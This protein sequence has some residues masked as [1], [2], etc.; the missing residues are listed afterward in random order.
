MI[1]KVEFEMAKGNC[2]KNLGL[3][4]K[5]IAGKWKAILDG[6]PKNLRIGDKADETLAVFE[7]S[8]RPLHDLSPVMLQHEHAKILFEKATKV[9]FDESETPKD[10]DVPGDEG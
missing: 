9:K 3:G 7:K 5:L 8:I 4:N 10:A 6:V 2:E 1:S